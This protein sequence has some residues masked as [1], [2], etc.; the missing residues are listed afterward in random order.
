MKRA[1][2]PSFLIAV[3]LVAIVGLAKAQQPK[4]YRIGVLLPGEAWHETIEGLRAGLKQLGL[5]EGKQFILLIRDMKGNMKTAENAGK[6]LEREKVDLLYT[7]STNT[8][9]AAKRVTQDI[10]IVFN[11]GADPVAHGLVESFAKPGGRFTGVYYLI[12]DLTGKRLEI[13]KEIVPKLRRVVTFYDPRY[14]AAI[15]SSK[16][17]R[18]TAERLKV[19]LVERHITSVEELRAGMQALRAGEVDAYFSVTDP[20]VNSQSQLI[21][22]TARVKKLPTMFNF[23]SFVGKGGLASY[24]V[25][26]YEVGR[27]SAKY[28]QRVLT[29]VKP[30]DLPVQEVDKVALVINLKTAKAI[31]LTISQWTLMKADKVIK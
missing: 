27:L 13:L 19:E 12:T 8:S 17:A 14:P 4:I 25:N 20:M 1:A 30:K 16:L 7:T 3:A 29:G 26:F 5:E 28:V 6:N 31:G 2:A 24:S 15:E 23:L 11:A 9:M 10:S 21:I 22:E 18:E